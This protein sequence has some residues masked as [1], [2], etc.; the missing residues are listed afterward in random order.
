MEDAHGAQNSLE[1]CYQEK[2]YRS[3]LLPVLPHFTGIGMS[4]IS[5]RVVSLSGF[6]GKKAGTSSHPCFIQF[7]NNNLFGD[8][9]IFS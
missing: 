1:Y 4:D 9:S 2:D 8:P 3:S 5:C 7:I 6:T